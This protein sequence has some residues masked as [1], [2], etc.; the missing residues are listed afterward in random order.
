MG[1]FYFFSC[2]HLPFLNI[3]ESMNY[4]LWFEDVSAVTCG[5]PNMYNPIKN[6]GAIALVALI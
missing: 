5:F 4:N 2:K 1:Y 6:L 3:N